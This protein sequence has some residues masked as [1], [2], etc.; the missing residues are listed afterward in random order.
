MDTNQ[1]TFLI[2]RVVEGSFTPFKSYDARVTTF[3]YALA[4]Y[5]KKHYNC[6]KSYDVYVAS[7]R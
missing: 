6:F 7:T 1:F 4:F 5:S 2:Y 3:N